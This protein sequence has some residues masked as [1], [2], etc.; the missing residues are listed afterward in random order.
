MVSELTLVRKKFQAPSRLYF[1]KA[2]QFWHLKG[3]D[4]LYAILACSVNN[5]AIIARNNPTQLIK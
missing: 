2:T 4:V 3:A 1:S 5:L